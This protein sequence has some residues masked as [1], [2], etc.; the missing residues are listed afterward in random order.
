MI[1][2]LLAPFYDA[3]NS[4]LDY[5]AWADFIEK[6]VNKESSVRPELVLDLGSGTGRMTL[7]RARRGYDMTGVDYSPEMLGVARECAEL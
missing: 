7:E 2:D 3:I 1:Y 4:E 5:C 6:I